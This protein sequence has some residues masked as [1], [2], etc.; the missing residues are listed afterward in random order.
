MK[1]SWGTARIG[2]IA[3]LTA[4]T[5][6]ATQTVSHAQLAPTVWPMFG[7]DSRHTALSTV[8]TSANPGKLKWVYD[9]V[10]QNST[11]PVCLNDSPAIG[12][13]GTIYVGCDEFLY[14]VNAD[15]T[16]K[17]KFA[18]GELIQI[19]SPAIGSDGTI[20]IGSRDGNLYALTDN[21]T[22]ATQK[23]A[24]AT[25]GGVFSSPAI[26]AD[27]TIYFGSAD[28]NL[29]AVN[30]DGTQKWK[31]GNRLNSKGFSSGI[32]SPAIGANGIIYFGSNKNLYA[33]A[34]G[35][36]GTVTKKWV[37]A[38][39]GPMYGSPTIGA[40]GTIYVG[41]SDGNLYAVT[42]NGRRFKKK[43]RFSTG[44]G[45]DS[46][47]SIGADGTIY[48]TSNDSKFYAITDHGT[49][50][51]RK[52]A[53][54][55]GAVSSASLTIGADGTIFGSSE[56]GNLYALTDS[57]ASA[58]EKWKIR[59]D[60]GLSSPVI[61]ADGTIYVGGTYLDDLFAVGTPPSP[62]A[63]DLGISSTSLDFGT[64][65]PGNFATMYVTVSNPI[66]SM[67]MPGL[68]VQ[69]QGQQLSGYGD[70]TLMNL[71][72]APLQAGENCQI[73]VTFAPSGKESQ[74]RT[75]MIFDNANNAPQIVKLKGAGG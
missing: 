34:D 66:G 23:W 10:D 54:P 32:S 73:G 64:L 72:V 39:A 74:E 58:T 7:H 43:W 55:G 1:T 70:F 25:G 35:G 48:F 13:D 46:S 2:A 60:G 41:S 16:L 37:F 75:M 31:F 18:L 38:T 22:N 69:M 50:A 24:F 33:I 49:H 62:V 14:A 17:W 65:K 27:G 28:H 40:D 5:V 47:P 12:A 15:G 42:D 56:N 61:G 57:G 67:A 20:Y 44:G 52:W 4:I 9:M 21:G 53:F 8:D 71:C 68:A 45:V 51:T 59:V 36:Q 19:S 26:S 29:Y 11:S 63:V 6:V 30:P 3:A